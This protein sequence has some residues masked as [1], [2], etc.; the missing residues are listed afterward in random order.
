VIQLNVVRSV[1]LIVD[2]IN[3]AH[4]TG[5]GYPPLG[6]E[7][8]KLKMKL[9]P[10]LRIEDTLTQKLAPNSQHHIKGESPDPVFDSAS[11]APDA[12]AVPIR[13]E[14]TVN[15]RSTWKS[16][17]KKWAKGGVEEIDF[18][19]PTDPGRVL[20]A[21]RDDIIAL[22]RDPV[23]RQILEIARVRPQDQGGL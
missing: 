5:E 15:S 9:S 12:P 23:V 3:M 20:F 16:A 18:D 22:W 8:L 2:T 6:P 11:V 14:L 17:F 4:Q 1:R 10:L 21:C 19:D 13:T 7:Q